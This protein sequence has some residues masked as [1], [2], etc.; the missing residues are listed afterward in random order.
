MR[1]GPRIGDAPARGTA[2]RR[3][4]RDVPQREGEASP[5]PG[6]EDEDP[7]R[8]LLGSGGGHQGGQRVDR[9]LGQL[10]S[11]AR[12]LLATATVL[13][14]RHG[15]MAEVSADGDRLVAVAECATGDVLLEDSVEIGTAEAECAHRRAAH[16]AAGGSQARSSVLMRKGDD[17]QSMLGFGCSNP[18]LG[19]STFS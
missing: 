3:L 2:F 14:D 17:A 8:R 16:T 4:G 18:R 19:G 9:R 6:S 11:V 13:G 10:L 5:V 12:I 1:R 7:A 15:L